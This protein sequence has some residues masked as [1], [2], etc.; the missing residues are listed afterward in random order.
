MARGEGEQD[1]MAANGNSM[2]AARIV[3]AELAMDRTN[4]FGYRASGDDGRHLAGEVGALRVH[5]LSLQGHIVR[6]RNGDWRL[7]ARLRARVVQ[8]CISTLTHL[9]TR[10][11]SSVQR[12]YVADASRMA[13]QADNRI[14]D[15]DSLEPLGA[16]IDL[17]ELAREALIL[18]MP[19]YPRAP[20]ACES[21]ADGRDGHGVPGT[22]PLAGLA[23]FYR[24]LKEDGLG[25]GNT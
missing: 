3:V 20:S 5:G 4:T 11:N 22:R 2:A 13:C 19:L 17:A 12:T 9:T 18:E 8:Q 23:D 14:P 16:V 7:E 1:I 21:P 25:P 15:D 10:I 24:L 6:R